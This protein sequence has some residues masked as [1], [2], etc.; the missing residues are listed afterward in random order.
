MYGAFYFTV[1]NLSK[2]QKMKT[3]TFIYDVSVYTGYQKKNSYKKLSC[4]ADFTTNLA[5]PL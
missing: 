3:N 2:L 5:K 4:Q 1:K